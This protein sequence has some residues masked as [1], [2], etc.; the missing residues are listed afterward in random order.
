MPTI[1]PLRHL[2]TLPF[3]EAAQGYKANQTPPDPLPQQAEMIS[4]CVCILV[5][6]TSVLT[7]CPLFNIRG[8]S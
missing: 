4:A 2:S 6:L 8:G 5:W 3:D 7:L 1:C